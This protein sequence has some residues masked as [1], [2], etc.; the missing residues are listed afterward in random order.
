MPLCLGARKKAF[1]FA[2]LCSAAS[3]A[4][5]ATG[6]LIGRLLWW[7]EGTFS[8]IAV[9]FFTY[10]PGFTQ[11]KFFHLQSLYEQYDFW[12]IFTAGFT[13][14]P[15]KVITISAG[16]FTVNFWMFILASLL[17]RS[18]RFFLVAGI[19]YVMGERAKA[20]IDK[21]FNFLSIAFI[22]MLIGGFAV[23]KWVG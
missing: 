23:I 15:F 22:I 1:W 12:I 20:F 13:P 19:F 8:D 16:A 4:G 11:D 5:G 17:S 14:L 21:Y 18:A 6:Y 3:V 7:T 10:I 9:F 2:F